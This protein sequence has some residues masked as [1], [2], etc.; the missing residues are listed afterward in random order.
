[1]PFMIEV[2]AVLAGAVEDWGGFG[3]ILALPFINAPIGFLEEW[4]AQGEVNAL[5]ASLKTTASVKRDG[6]FITPGSALMVPGDIFLIKGGMVV[7]AGCE[8]LEGD[9]IA[10]DTSAL[11]GESLPRKVPD[12]QGGRGLLSGFV[13]K[14]GKCLAKVTKAGLTAEMGETAALVHAAS[15]RDT[16]GIFEQKIMNVCEVVILVTLVVTAIIVFVQ[17]YVRGNSFQNVI[18]MALS[19]VIASVPVALPMVMQITMAI[20]ARKMADHKA[21]VTHLTALQEVASMT[22]LCSDKTGTLTTANITVMPDQIWVS[23][24]TE[25]A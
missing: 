10:V 16:Q 11:T 21:I 13:V 6:R 3:I 23:S 5:R 18:L 25:A 1:M 2:A 12:R 8:W 14:P 19:L 24:A 4:K 15:E 17:I 22:V 9:E 20:G 7:P